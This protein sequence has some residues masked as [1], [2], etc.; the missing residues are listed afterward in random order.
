MDQDPGNST[1]IYLLKVMQ[2]Q[3]FAAEF[4][5]LQSPQSKK[6]KKSTR[7]IKKD[8]NLFINLRK[9]I[10][11]KGR[12]SKNTTDKDEIIDPVLVAKITI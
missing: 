8:L 12:I 3:S 2:Q 11:T 6:K 5:Y 10:R 7:V 1:K 9:R 4:A